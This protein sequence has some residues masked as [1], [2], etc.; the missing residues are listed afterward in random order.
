MRDEPHITLAYLERALLLVLAGMLLLGIIEVVRPFLTSILFG[1]VLAVATWPARE[2]LLRAGVRRGVAAT[3]LLFAAL[4]LIVAP[5][6]LLAP[7]LIHQALLGGKQIL[8][9]LATGPHTPPH[10][11]ASL[12]LVGDS[13]GKLWDRIAS[14]EINTLAPYS[15]Q[16]RQSLLGLATGLLDSLLQL[17]LSL[18]VAT[19][20]WVTGPELAA[21]LRAVLDRIGGPAA[22]SAV[23]TIGASIRGVAYGVVGTAFLQGGWVAIGLALAGIKGAV[24]LGLAALVFA[25]S[26]IGLPL[27]YAIDLG[28]AWWCFHDGRI[29]WAI[30]LLLWCGPLSAMDNLVRPWLISFG[31]PMPLSLVILGV[32]GGFFSFGFLGL[33]IGPSLLAVAYTLWKTWRNLPEGGTDGAAG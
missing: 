7:G 19:L 1:S 30:F 17:L 21:E 11:L 13:A 3:V 18:G 29:G 22:A 31:V 24:V 2:A 15:A 14:G 26:Q 27:V 5:T 16:L 4:A 28:A 9:F 10:W 25:L 32:F 12:P 6:V 33:F 20:F 8:A 23:N